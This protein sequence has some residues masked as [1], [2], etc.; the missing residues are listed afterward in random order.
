MRRLF[1]LGIGIGIGALVVRA[2][3]RRVQQFTPSGLAGTAQ[4]SIGNVA[5]SVRNFIDDVREGMA[6]REDEIRTAFSDGVALEPPQLTWAH[7]VGEKFYQFSAEQSR[8]QQ[9]GDQQR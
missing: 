3:T 1:W 8:Q 2:V 5:G 9:E 6:E 4:E 7:G